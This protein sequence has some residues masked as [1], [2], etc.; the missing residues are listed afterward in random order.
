MVD[1][2]ITGAVKAGTTSLHHYL[3]QHPHIEMSRMKWPRFFH[4]D[5]SVPNFDK[6]ATRFGNELFDESVRRFRLMCHTGIPRTYEQYLDQWSQDPA[7][8]LRGEASPTYMYDDFACARIKDRYPNA[9]II[10]VLRRPVDRALSHFTMDLAN[11]WV[12]DRIFADAV[13]AEPYRIDNF[14]WGLRHYLRHGFYARH[15][16][17]AFDIFDRQ[18][19]MVTFYDEMLND[20]KTF[21]N[22]LTD[23]LKL[24]RFEFDLSRWHNQTPVEKAAV[25]EKL[26]EALTQLYRPK[27][28][29]LELIVG[30]DLH[31][32]Y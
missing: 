30:R 15:L 28:N 9:K 8:L 18:N 29:E 27:I 17:R 20:P 3:N 13:M 1:F 26:M 4:I 14:W 16:R 11:K 32:W 25:P 10:I 21:M 24:E 31:N 6:L 2:F 19:V 5:G 7:I 23:F 22:S 12:P